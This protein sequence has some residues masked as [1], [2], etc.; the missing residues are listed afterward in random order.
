MAS[1]A[2]STDGIM[3]LWTT[4]LAA[5]IVSFIVL[6]LKERKDTQQI[7]D[8]ITQAITE[9]KATDNRVEKSKDNLSE[10]HK[11]ISKEITYTREALAKD[12]TVIVAA[13]ENRDNLSNQLLGK[14]QDVVKYLEAL[15][16]FSDIM[17]DNRHEITQLKEA[18]LK[19]DEKYAELQ[20][21]FEEEKCRRKAAEQK[22]REIKRS[23]EYEADYDL[24]R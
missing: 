15:T 10:E 16:S 7:K 23:Q 1:T 3:M 8:A 12:L 9:N 2:A 18:L 14:E 22:L 21:S 24:D 6:I 20:N 19:S 17:M 13:K 4:A 5:A 11:D